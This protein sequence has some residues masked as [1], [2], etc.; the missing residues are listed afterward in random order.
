MTYQDN[1]RDFALELVEEGRISAEGLLKAC[2]VFMSHDDVREMLD[3]N[4]LSPRFIEGDQA[5]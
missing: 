1:P 5:G 4:E 3:D 2:L